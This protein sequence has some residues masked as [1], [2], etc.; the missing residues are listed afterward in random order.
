MIEIYLS[1]LGSYSGC[2]HLFHLGVIFS[3]IVIIVIVCHGPLYI[4][5]LCLMIESYL[6]ILGSYSSCLHLL[7]LGAIF[8]VIVIIFILCHGPLDRKGFFLES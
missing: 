2:I 6:S 3:F 1:I 7:H 4:V 5:V 8:S